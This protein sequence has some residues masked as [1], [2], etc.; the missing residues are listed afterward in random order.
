MIA[1]ASLKCEHLAASFIAD[2]SDFF[3]IEPSWEW[4]NLTS[5]VL[6]S[7]LLTPDGNPIEIEAMLQA[8]ATAATRMPRLEM[9]E[10][11]NGRKGFAALFKYEAFR[12][13]HQATITW[14]GTW[15]FTVESSVIQA[16]E[17]VMQPY[18]GWRLNLVQEQLD[19]AAI[20]SHGDAIHHL[21]LSSQLIRP[22]SLHQIQME[23]KALEGVA[24]V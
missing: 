4:S 23:Q 8:A 17:A 24:T 12:H 15:K 21:M 3:E 11:W 6:T 18:D 7:K 13:T 14:R 20:K 10:I 19:E 2:A 9:M 22:V 1:L 16:W 5:L